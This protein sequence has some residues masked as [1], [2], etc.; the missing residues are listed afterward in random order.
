MSKAAGVKLKVAASGRR[1]ESH[2]RKRWSTVHSMP[3]KGWSMSRTASAKLKVAA[4]GRRSE[5]QVLKR[6]STALSMHRAGWSTSRKANVKLKVAARA[7]RSAWQD[8][9]GGVLCRACPGRDGQCQ[10][11]QV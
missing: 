5:W 9:N 2:V 6:R 10:G 7:R 3:W 8:E 4:S 1:L 11:Q